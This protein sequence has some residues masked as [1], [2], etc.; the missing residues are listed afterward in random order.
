MPPSFHIILSP[1]A[2]GDLET[3]HEYIR[4][5]SPQNAAKVVGRILDAIGTLETFPHRNIV[6]SKSRKIKDPVRSLPVKPYIIYFRVLDRQQAVHILTVRHAARRPPRRFY[7][8]SMPA[9]KFSQPG[10]MDLSPL[11]S[12]CSNSLSIKGM[13]C[14]TK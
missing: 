5:D 7:S 9:N 2:A 8:S 13:L 4:K 6:E 12:S 1:E 14:E 11:F 3:L 10:I